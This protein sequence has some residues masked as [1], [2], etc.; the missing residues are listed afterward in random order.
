VGDVNV[1]S[2]AAIRM[3][4]ASGAPGNVFNGGHGGGGSGGEI[5]IQSFAP[6]VISSTAFLTV[7]GGNVN[8]A[9]GNQAAGR[10]GAGLYQ[11]EDS[12]GI[13]A[14]NFAGIPLGAANVAVVQFPYSTTVVGTAVSTFFDT[15][16]GAPD[17]TFVAE[18]ASLGTVPGG[19]LGITY[20]G[21]FESVSG[22]GPDLSTPTAPV[23]GA[24]ID[25]LD[26]RRFIRFTIA[27]SYS[28]PPVSTATHTFPSY[29]VKRRLARPSSGMLDAVGHGCAPRRRPDP[30]WHPF[31]R[32]HGRPWAGRS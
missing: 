9:C 23:P 21:A 29:G 13:V 22:G 16:Y 4:G 8:T 14:T 28:S 5:W 26:G 19:T 18:S 30:A 25:S 2:G 32:G 12:D 7:D 10:G 31:G 20:Q 15:G 24:A 1:G 3:N 27:V 6:I 11:F 17:Y